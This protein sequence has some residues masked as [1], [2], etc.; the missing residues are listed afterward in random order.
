MEISVDDV[1]AWLDENIPTASTLKNY[2]VRIRPVLAALDDTKVYQA[3]KDKT[4]LKLILEKG[5]SS[6]TMKGKTQVFLKL[7][8]EYPGL[9]EAVGEKVYEIYNKFFLE[10]NADMAAGY[11]Q[12]AIVQDE[13]DAI[14]PF[15]EIKKKV[16]KAFPAGSDERLYM[17]LY[18]IA[19]VRDDFGE[20]LIVK[21]TVDTLDKSKNYY[22]MSNHQLVINEHKSKNKYGTLRYKLPKEVYQLIDTMNQFVFE[23]G[24][25]LSS[26]VSKMLG[27]IGIDGAINVLRHAYLSEQLDGENIKDPVIRKN[28]F[29]KM[30][31]SQSAQ[32]GYLRKL[33]D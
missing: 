22:V 18:E 27:K 9:L 29:Q 12:K 28:L 5:G 8:K 26:F 32:L 7:I 23:H 10:A 16:F 20:L 33:K 6:S 2:K 17:E 3:I 30:A 15:S 11:I 14:E 13:E 31:H 1:Y 19:P 4:I 21:K 24:S 25:T